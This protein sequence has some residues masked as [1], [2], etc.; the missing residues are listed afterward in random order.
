MGSFTFPYLVASLGF[1]AALN[2][3]VFRIDVQNAR[4]PLH[5]AKRETRSV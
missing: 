1:G 4:K 5:C 3:Q 2:D